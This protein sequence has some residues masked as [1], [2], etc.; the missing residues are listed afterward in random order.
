[1][2]VCWCRKDCD[3][4]GNL[5]AKRNGLVCMVWGRS[6]AMARDRKNSIAPPWGYVVFPVPT[7][8]SIKT[9]GANQQ[10]R[11]LGKTKSQIIDLK[12]LFKFGDKEIC[13]KRPVSAAL[14]FVSHFCP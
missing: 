3:T 7:H 9:P 1:M 12:M 2:F 8:P 11:D 13:F 10:P 14:S 5:K 6:M 4:D